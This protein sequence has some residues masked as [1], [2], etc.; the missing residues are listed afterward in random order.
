MYISVGYCGK[1][2]FW[3][4]LNCEQN[5]SEFILFLPVVHNNIGTSL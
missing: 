2:T 3:I 4:K 1:H 5:D